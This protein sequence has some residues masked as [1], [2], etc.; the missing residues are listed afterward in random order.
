[1]GSGKT[2]RMKTALLRTALLAAAALLPLAPSTVGAQTP[3]EVVDAATPDEWQE[4]AA[5]DLVVMILTPDA[6]GDERE[7]VIQLM[8]EPFSANWVHNVRELAR[9]HWWDGLSVYRSV[10]NWVVQWGAGE[11]EKPMPETI[12]DTSADDY[13][14]NWESGILNTMWGSFGRR[15]AEETYDNMDGVG[16]W[17]NDPYSSAIGFAQGLPVASDL[18]TQADAQGE[19]INRPTEIW[20]VHCYASVGVA[21]ALAP[22]AGTGAELYVVIGHAPRQLDRNIAVV[23]KVIDGV[24][25]LSVLPRGTGPAGVY[26]T[27]AEHTQIISVRLASEMAEDERPRY[28]FLNPDSGSF[29]DWAELKANRADAFYTVPAGGADVCNLSVPV[30]PVEDEAG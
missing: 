24:E 12:R 26:E 27:E 18:E 15:P 7:V 21:R 4:I 30:E 1:M 14:L 3:K 16:S 29:A 28:R 23:G 10:D 8:P 5:D 6:A 13:T 11:A 25:H 9:A 19:R 20:P 2:A 17:F 22:S